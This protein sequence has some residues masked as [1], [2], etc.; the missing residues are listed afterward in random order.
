V[1]LIYEAGP[2]ELPDGIRAANHAE[3]VVSRGHSGLLA[4]ALDAIGYEDDLRSCFGR[5]PSWFDTFREMNGDGVDLG[6]AD[7]SA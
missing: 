2:Q 6:F 7:R 1:Q 3:I 5:D 4:G